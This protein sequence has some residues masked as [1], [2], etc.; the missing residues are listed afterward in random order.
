M[1]MVTS[2]ELMTGVLATLHKAM[3]MIETPQL[4]SCAFFLMVGPVL[5]V[6]GPS[7]QN[8]E[9]SCSGL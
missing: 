7:L 8:Q 1:M 4:I 3:N 9:G 5:R 2:Y 6:D